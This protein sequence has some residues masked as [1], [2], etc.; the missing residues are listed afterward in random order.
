M[1]DITT[2][3]PARPEEERQLALEV[4][5]FEADRNAAAT[6]RILAE[7]HELEIPAATIRA[8]ANRYDWEAKA[9]DLFRT[10][11]PHL[12]ERAAFLLMRAALPAARYILDVT[13]GKA[14]PDK[15]RLAAA[16]SALNRTGFLPFSRNLAQAQAELKASQ[17][18]EHLDSLDPLTH[19]TDDEL[20]RLAHRALT[21]PNPND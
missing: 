10:L 15:T 14:K 13:E 20:E 9:S 17:R 8:W 3:G 5:A 6:S 19:L 18:A 4:W 12:Y 16:D 2:I 1:G 7:S 11:T 21:A